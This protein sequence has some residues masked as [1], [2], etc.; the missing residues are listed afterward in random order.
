MNLW[1]WKIFSIPFSLR[2]LLLKN[3]IWFCF[4]HPSFFVYRK[5]RSSVS[6]P[7]S[8][9]SQWHLLLILYMIFGELFFIKYGN[10]SFGSGEFPCIISMIKI[11]TISSI[12]HFSNSYYFCPIILY[13]CPSFILLSL[14]YVLLSSCLAF[15]KFSLSFIAWVE[16]LKFCCTFLIVNIPF[17]SVFLL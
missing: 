2:Y 12:L 4:K 16:L 6:P 9:I 7:N 14:F 11:I 8:G 15:W 17:L 5:L 10:I 3:E 13:R 1:I